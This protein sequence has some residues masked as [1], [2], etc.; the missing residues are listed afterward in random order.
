MKGGTHF[1]RLKD[2]YQDHG[3]T[4]KPDEY[5]FRNIGTLNSRKDDFVGRPLSDSFLRKLWYEFSEETQAYHKIQFQRKYTL[6]SCRSF[7]I[8]QMLMEG[9]EPHIV[10]KLVGHSVKVC[11]R[12]Y[13]EI[14]MMQI[15]DQ[16]VE[17]RK[18]DLSKKGFTPF[19][20]DEIDQGFPRI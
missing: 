2:H 3:Y 13:E 10:A 7:F 9:H 5:V 18:V 6:Y 1:K 14:K 20:V 16:L 8:N 11:E 17:L 12:H 19:E 4:T 15:S